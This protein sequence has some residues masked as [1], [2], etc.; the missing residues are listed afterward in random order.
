[1]LD[2]IYSLIKPQYGMIHM[3]NVLH[4]CEELIELTGECYLKDKETR[5][6]AIDYICNL[7]ESQKTTPKE[8]Q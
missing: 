6:Q 8:L 4:T 7:L 2:E 5:N 3:K 1:M